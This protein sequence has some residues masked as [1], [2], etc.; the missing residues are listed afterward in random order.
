M[1]RSSVDRSDPIAHRIANAKRR[2][3]Q[4]I[5]I[6]YI[7]FSTFSTFFRYRTGTGPGTGGR[8]PDRWSGARGGVVSHGRRDET[9]RRVTLPVRTY[10]RV[11]SLA[12]VQYRTV[13]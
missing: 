4:L 5:A 9:R 3:N 7:F 8:V 10:R 1:I 13:Q 2:S 12:S 6:F 11:R